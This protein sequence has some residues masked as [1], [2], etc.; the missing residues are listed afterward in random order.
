MCLPTFFELD[1]Q[2]DG[3]G[4]DVDQRARGECALRQRPGFRRAIFHHQRGRSVELLRPSQFYRLAALIINL[5]G[6]TRPLE[7]H[8]AV[9]TL[10]YIETDP[11][12]LQIELEEGWEDTIRMLEPHAAFFTFA[13]NLGHP[14]CRLPVTD[15]FDFRPTRQPVLLDR[16]A[17][18]D[19][20]HI[21]MPLVSPPSGTGASRS[22]RCTS[23]VDTYTWSKDVEFVK[24]LGTARTYALA[25]RP[26]A[27]QPHRS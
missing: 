23:A 17:G 11:V 27:G 10:I 25:V 20:C 16:W 26:R 18:S 12:T 14:S 22:A 21:R 24:I 3:I 5:H 2:R 19:S 15:R 7:E 1:L 4:L 9:G 8:M 6:G 13:E